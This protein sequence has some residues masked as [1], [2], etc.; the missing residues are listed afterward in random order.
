MAE[1]IKFMKDKGEEIKMEDR[2]KQYQGKAFVK[3]A[4]YA[5]L[6]KVQGTIQSKE[7]R[8]NVLSLAFDNIELLDFGDG[9]QQIPGLVNPTVIRGDNLGVSIVLSPAFPFFGH[10]VSWDS[11]L[12]RYGLTFRISRSIFGL[13]SSISAMDPKASAWNG[14]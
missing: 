8:W 13:T 12:S 1:E 9:I 5:D 11:L 7:F 6:E 2:K 14:V 4:F 3:A 10:H